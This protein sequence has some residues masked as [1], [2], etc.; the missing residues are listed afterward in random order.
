MKNDD[1]I[2]ADVINICKN[3]FILKESSFTSSR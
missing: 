2:Q 3:R 1:I